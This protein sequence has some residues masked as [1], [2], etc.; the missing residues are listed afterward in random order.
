VITGHHGFFTQPAELHMRP[1]AHTTELQ[2]TPIFAVPSEC[3]PLCQ[4]N[5]I[6]FVITL[7][8]SQLTMKLRESTS[9][10]DDIVNMKRPSQCDE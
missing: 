8:G 10:S 6:Y 3:I 9:M 4:N 7:S 1:L 5:P 2:E